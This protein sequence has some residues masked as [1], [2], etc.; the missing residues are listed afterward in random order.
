MKRIVA[1]GGGE[2]RLNE[3]FEID[4]QI[5]SAIQKSKPRVL[6]IPTASNEPDG[7]IQRINELYGTRLGCD[8]STLFLIEGKT[9]KETA[10]NMILSSDIIYVGGGNTKNMLKVWREYSVDDALKEAYEEGIVLT[11]LSAGSICWFESGHSDSNINDNGNDSSFIKLEALGL[12]QGIHCPHYNEKGRRTDFKKMILSTNEVGIA[13]DN[14]CAIEFLDSN[15]RIIKSDIKAKAYKVYRSQ[16]NIIEKELINT[17]E[18][19]TIESLY[20]KS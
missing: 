17:K 14:N 15:Y 5:V 9:S 4:S 10:R 20:I 16:G 13:L 1:I 12:I 11:G 6:F 2:I 7:Y 8:V 3:T 19:K 18:Y